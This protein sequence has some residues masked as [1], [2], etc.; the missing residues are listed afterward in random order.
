MT[1]GVLESWFDLVELCRELDESLVADEPFP[2]TLSLHE[3]VVNLAVG[4]GS[5]L[6]HQIRIRGA[7]IPASGQTY[8]T[9]KASLEMLRIFH[10]T[11]HPE[12]SP[13]EIEIVRQRVF[14]TT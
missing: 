4:C 2:E 5:W 6:L 13:G 9:L 8:E 12:F 10:R 11:R 7:D 14:A 1:S 3:A